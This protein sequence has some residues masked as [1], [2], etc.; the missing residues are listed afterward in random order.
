[1]RFLICHNS[2]LLKIL[3]GI[4]DSGMTFS[5]SCISTDDNF[6]ILEFFFWN[7]QYL[8]EICNKRILLMDDLLNILKYPL[9]GVLVIL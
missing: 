7:L 5:W 8:L 2:K 9:H 4:V 1:M 3:L 6:S